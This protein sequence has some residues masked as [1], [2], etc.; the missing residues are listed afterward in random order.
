M[1]TA[2]LLTGDF[3]EAED[4]VQTTLAKVYGRWRWVPRAEIDLYV[5]RALVNNNLS[6]LRRKRVAHLLT[7]VLPFQVPGRS[8][9]VLVSGE[10]LPERPPVPRGRW[11]VV[12][13]HAGFPPRA[14]PARV[15]DLGD[16]IDPPRLESARW[17][18]TALLFGGR[19]LTA[20]TWLEARYPDGAVHRVLPE[21]CG[22]ELK[23]ELAGFVV[24]DEPFP[25]V[26]VNPPPRGGR[27]EPIWIPRPRQA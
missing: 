7:P 10:R 9:E 18:G 2:Q 1:R 23:V 17:E 21:L 3:H 15:L 4:L 24:P 12:P 27:S 13:I 26:A 11:R 20:S 5:R 16:A 14:G 6:R 8:L 25:V 19:H 22:D